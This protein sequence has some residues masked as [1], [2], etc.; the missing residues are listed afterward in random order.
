MSGIFIRNSKKWK[1]I[2]KVLSLPPKQ[3]QSV[4]RSQINAAFHSMKELH[5]FDLG[6]FIGAGINGVVFRLK[7]ITTTKPNREREEEDTN[8]KPMIVK[9][10]RYGRYEGKMQSK[11]ARHKLAPSVWKSVV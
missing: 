3:S 8:N 1:V 4:F 11:F 2:C 9:L 6:A 10:F 5:N 7:T